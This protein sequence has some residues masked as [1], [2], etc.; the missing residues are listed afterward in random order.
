[1]SSNIIDRQMLAGSRR[2]ELKLISEEII[3]RVKVFL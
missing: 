2:V 1:M 3:I